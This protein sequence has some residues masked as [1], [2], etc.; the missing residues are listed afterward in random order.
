M[1]CRIRGGWTRVV[2]FGDLSYCNGVDATAE[3]L[4]S[5]FR[6]FIVEIQRAL[7]DQGLVKGIQRVVENWQVDTE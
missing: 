5:E 2:V 7:I 3:V 6:A 4:G 1:E